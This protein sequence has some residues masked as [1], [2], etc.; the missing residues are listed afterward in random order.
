MQVGELALKLDQ[1]VIVAGDV[2]GAAGAGAHFGRGFDHGADDLGVLAHAEIVVRAPDHDVT[3]PLRRVPERMREAPGDTL[4]VGKDAV[5]TL[6][7]QPSQGIGEKR[8][9]IHRV[10]PDLG[11]LIGTLPGYF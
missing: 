4:E 5:A 9:I 7:V 6:G 11:R 1:R 8:V 3:R 2:A 10:F